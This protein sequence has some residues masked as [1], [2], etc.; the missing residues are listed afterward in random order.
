MERLLRDMPLFVEVAKRRSFTLAAD[1]LDMPVSTL[2]RRIAALEKELGLP[3]LRRNS[4]NVELTESGKEFF[5]RCDFIVAEA[6]MARDI[7][8][9]N[10]KSPTGRVRI[11]LTG[12]IYHAYMRG[13][14]S[15]F[16]AEWPGIHLQV[17]FSERA[18]DLLTEPFDLDIR[19]GPLPDSGLKARRLITLWPSLYASPKLLES[20]SAPKEPRDLRNTPCITLAQAGD[21]WTMRK[22]KR[23]ASITLSRNRTARW[24]TR[25][26]SFQSMASTPCLPGVTNA[27]RLMEPRLQAS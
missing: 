6:E 9:R 7:V 13:A 25:R 26:S 24:M 20:Y 15:A 27:A 22:G 17:H 1:A 21:R 2:S 4:R 3:L 14:F 16:A 11:A 19:R 12:D 18:V 8:T 23:E 10:M 5:E